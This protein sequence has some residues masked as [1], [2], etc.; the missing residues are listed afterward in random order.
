MNLIF[1]T[2]TTPTKKKITKMYKNHYQ[3]FFL[4]VHK[5]EEFMPESS[6]NVIREVS[7]SEE[8]S[9]NEKSSGNKNKKSVQ[10][11]KENVPSQKSRDSEKRGK[12]EIKGIS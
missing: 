8:S 10:K 2:P 9:R 12:I 7:K 5:K 3:T 6:K 4:F 11:G 1:M